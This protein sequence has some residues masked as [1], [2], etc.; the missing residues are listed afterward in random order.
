MA[1]TWVSYK[2]KL[3]YIKQDFS[4][5]PTCFESYGETAWVT[6]KEKLR[7]AF[8]GISDIFCEQIGILIQRDPHKGI[9]PNFPI[10]VITG[11]HWRIYTRNGFL[12]RSGESK[13]VAPGDPP[14]S[15]MVEGFPQ[16]IDAKLAE[17]HSA[18]TR[19]EA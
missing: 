1:G 17:Y 9:S 11:L 8:T 19:T 12:L 16:A 10:P 4:E 7:A 18:R 6:S 2:T 14:I 5:Y 15:F 13:D 3:Y